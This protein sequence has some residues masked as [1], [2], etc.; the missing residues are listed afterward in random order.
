MFATILRFQRSGALRGAPILGMAGRTFSS[1]WSVI[2]GKK[3]AIWLTLRITGN[4]RES[5]VG[6]RKTEIRSPF[7]VLL[8][9][10]SL[11]LPITSYQPFTVL[12]NPNQKLLHCG[13][14]MI[15]IIVA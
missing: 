6:R 5:E 2:S 4:W 15:A 14:L 12:Q 10:F 11:Q 3:I 7:S 9:P 13:V 8:F 1:L